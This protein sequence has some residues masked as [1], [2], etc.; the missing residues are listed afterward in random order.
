MIC[1][2]SLLELIN[3]PLY[4]ASNLFFMFTEKQDLKV[5]IGTCRLLTKPQETQPEVVDIEMCGVQ[6]ESRSYQRVVNIYHLWALQLM[7]NSVSSNIPQET[8]HFV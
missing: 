5:D 2:Y 6:V 1:N 4:I 8:H 7:E 3:G